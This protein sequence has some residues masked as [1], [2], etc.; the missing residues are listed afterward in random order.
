MKEGDHIR[1]RACTA[2][3]SDDLRV[4]VV[5]MWLQGLDSRKCWESYAVFRPLGHALNMAPGN[6][7]VLSHSASWLVIELACPA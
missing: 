2:C 3:R 1:A 6:P 4:N 7:L 5:E